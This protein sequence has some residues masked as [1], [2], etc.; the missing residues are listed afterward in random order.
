MGAGYGG[1]DACERSCQW[2]GTPQSLEPTE[3]P[4]IM[5]E[6]RRKEKT[7]KARWGGR[8]SGSLGLDWKDVWTTA[9]V[10]HFMTGVGRRR[11]DKVPTAC[12]HQHT[13]ADPRSA[14]TVFR[15]STLSWSHQCPVLGT[16]ALSE[17]MF[18]GQTGPRAPGQI[19]S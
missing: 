11:A 15:K 7:V 6:T 17:L 12:H 14:H 1:R 13:W 16:L 10:E 9:G 5:K 8:I 18:A 4:K 3:H 2:L 19:R